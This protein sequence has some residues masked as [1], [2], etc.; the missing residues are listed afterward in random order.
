MSII[1][2]TQFMFIRVTHGRVQCGGLGMQKTKGLAVY[3]S[4]TSGICGGWCSNGSGVRNRHVHGRVGSAPGGR[5]GA[6]FDEASEPVVVSTSSI[7]VLASASSL[8]S[9]Q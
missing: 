9:A 4:H 6:R 7:Q 8:T 1:V 2:C 3:E 5:L